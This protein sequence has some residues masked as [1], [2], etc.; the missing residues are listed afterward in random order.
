MR[1]AWILDFADAHRVRNDFIFLVFPDPNFRALAG[2]KLSFLT[3][4][5]DRTG[6]INSHEWHWLTGV[7]GDNFQMQNRIVGLIW[8]E[9]A[10]GRI[11]YRSIRRRNLSELCQSRR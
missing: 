2:C 1:M 9:G 10:D 7:G 11:A 8:C 6:I 3:L 4:S 5:E